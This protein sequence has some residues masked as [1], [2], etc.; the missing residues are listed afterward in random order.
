[1]SQPSKVVHCRG[2][3]FDIT[4]VEVIALCSPFGTVENTLLMQQKHQALIQMATLEGAVALVTYYQRS[5]CNLRGSTLVFQYSNH[6]N[7]ET[8]TIT[9]T[10]ARM[11]NAGILHVIIEHAIYPINIDVIQQ[12]FSPYG[13]LKKAIIFQKK[14]VQALVQFVDP[15]FAENAMNALNGKNIYAG[16]C[17]LR[18]ELSNLEELK[19]AFNNEKSRDFMDNTLPT[20][21]PLG[22]GGLSLPGQQMNFGG[23]PPM[24][25]P[26]GMSGMGGVQPQTTGRSVMLVSN[27]DPAHVT[28]DV[29]FVLFGV[30]G[31]VIRVKIM[32]NKKDTALVQVMTDMQCAT[33]VKYLNNVPLFG[34]PMSVRTSHYTNIQLPKDAESQGASLNKE[35]TNSPLHR[36]KNPFSKNYQNITDPNT[37]LHVSN[38]PE[39]TTED[40]IRDLFSQ[41]G[42]V[43]NFKFFEKDPRMC[44]VQIDSLENAVS[45]LVALHNYQ[46]SPQRNLRITFS[47]N[48][49]SN[50]LT[51]SPNAAQPQ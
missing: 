12:V 5:P 15:H 24:G 33:C 22:G 3:P 48:K 38:L 16:C 19:V 43:V 20:N 39:G 26:Q 46:M 7:L 30:Y 40:Q 1:M 45:C 31:D 6:Q 28:P 18:I 23:L 21:G 4:E 42:S 47:K 41:Y 37:T 29:L 49:I 2:L 32:Y 8:K 35:Y 34:K 44:L 14:D 17:V 36:Y 11:N 10:N 51:S 13:A 25:M 50:N 9:N 27:L